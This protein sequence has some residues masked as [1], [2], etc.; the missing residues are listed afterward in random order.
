[1]RSSGDLL[2]SEVPFFVE[3]DAELSGGNLHA[4]QDN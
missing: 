1:M 3:V 4:S 2:I